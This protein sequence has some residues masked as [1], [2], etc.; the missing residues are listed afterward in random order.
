[1]K[2][3]SIASARQRGTKRLEEKVSRD[4]PWI[5]FHVFDCCSNSAYLLISSSQL[6]V[7]CEIPFRGS[8]QNGSSN[9]RL[10]SHRRVKCS[11]DCLYLV[12]IGCQTN[13]FAVF[14]IPRSLLKLSRLSFIQ[15]NS[16]RCRFVADT[17]FLFLIWGSLIILQH[18]HTYLKSG[19][20]TLGSKRFRSNSNGEILCT[21]QSSSTPLDAV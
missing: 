9:F 5:F 11:T 10:S 7:W 12:A 13:S 16:T 1:M 17:F 20:N 21:P 4:R 6:R 15:S 3:E 14:F 19:T 8:L 2:T 18:T